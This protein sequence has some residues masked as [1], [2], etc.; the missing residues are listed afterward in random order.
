M[1]AIA[2]GWKEDPD[3]LLFLKN[4]ALQDEN[5][6]V[7]YAAVNAIIQNWKENPELF[8]S[9]ANI[10]LNDPFKREYD[11]QYNPRQTALE[12]LLEN[13]GDNPKT[14]EILN[15]VALNDSDEKLRE[16]AQEKLKERET[17]GK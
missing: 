10:V 3:T 14:L 8:E 7:R 13:F 15:Q 5:G 1:N 12:A 16:F 9:L 2:Q 17:S 6:N 4:R 11:L